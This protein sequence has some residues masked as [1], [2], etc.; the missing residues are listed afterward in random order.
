MSDVR[1][2][3]SI[4]GVGRK[5]LLGPVEEEAERQEDLNVGSFHKDALV[6]FHRILQVADTYRVRSLH[7]ANGIQWIQDLAGGIH[8]SGDEQVF[9]SCYYT[10]TCTR[11][12]PQ[13]I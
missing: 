13:L 10:Q 6:N 7:I 1:T 2:Q 11:K 4:V 9:H 8:R 12:I 5:D 3:E